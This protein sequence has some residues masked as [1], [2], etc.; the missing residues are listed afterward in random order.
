MENGVA[1]AVAESL[2]NCVS[3][4]NK[5]TPK[6][7]TPATKEADKQNSPDKNEKRNGIGE[8]GK[9]AIK[10]DS[11]EKAA[12]RK[13]ESDS[14]TKLKKKDGGQTAKMG[15]DESGKV[16]MSQVAKMGSDESGKMKKISA[17]KA[18]LAVKASEE[19]LA[20]KRD[21]DESARA[22][23]RRDEEEAAKLNKLRELVNKKKEMQARREDSEPAGLVKASKER[24]SLMLP[25]KIAK[26]VLSRKKMSKER[27]RTMEERQRKPRIRPSD[28]GSSREKRQ[29]QKK[30]GRPPTDDMKTGIALA[31]E[32]ESKRA[33]RKSFFKGRFSREQPTDQS[34]KVKR[35][36]AATIAT[37]AEETQEEFSRK[38]I[39]ARRAS[40]SASRRERL[41]K[42]FFS[43]EVL[44]KGE[45]RELPN[46][47]VP[48][49]NRKKPQKK[50]QESALQKEGEGSSDSGIDYW[51]YPDGKPKKRFEITDIPSE[52]E[53]NY[54]DGKLPPAL[55]QP[56]P[57]MA[58][59][60]NQKPQMGG[61]L[62]TNLP[63][64]P[65]LYG[66]LDRPQRPQ[67][68]PSQIKPVS[69]PKLVSKQGAARKGTASVQLSSA[70][71]VFDSTTTRN[72]CPKR[73]K[74]LEF[75]ILIVDELVE[76]KIRP[77][78]LL[79]LTRKN[80]R[81]AIWSIQ[82]QVGASV[83]ALPDKFGINYASG[84]MD[85]LELLSQ[86]NQILITKA[87]EVIQL[88]NQFL[89]KLPLLMTDVVER[90]KRQ[91]SVVM[92]GIPEAENGLSP[93]MRL[94]H[95][96]KFVSG[97]L[98]S[99]DTETRPVEVYRMGR[100]VEGKPRIVKCVFSSR[101][102]ML[103]IL[104]KARCLRIFPKYKEVFV[105]RSMT[106]DERQKE[107]DLRERAREL[108]DN[109]F[110]GKKVY[111]VYKGAVIK[112]SEIPR[113]KKAH[114]STQPPPKN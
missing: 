27:D 88:L 93:S 98:D 47:E 95:T 4:V 25:P 21:S 42:Q 18:E 62:G 53:E 16:K 33:R 81:F 57:K 38:S 78:I 71:I 36:K 85:G 34:K 82:L 52:G 94:D 75:E 41:K 3:A 90:D 15:S 54:G 50:S 60:A 87:P 72:R 100:F 58:V 97:I 35:K 73:H 91:R 39:R 89:S 110:E 43:K 22:K 19:K 8:Q 7:T 11:D 92:Y 111:V 99:L 10:T 113:G 32:S 64:K 101:R 23:K 65:E 29:K 37:Q 59:P 2:K 61:N 107:R 109:E 104:S 84:E 86:I 1:I 80:I 6:K 83:F 112:A 66:V 14:S 96:E 28:Q 5:A 51:I 26:P 77:C 13:Q 30:L 56:P 12:L 67:Q 49:M 102:F 46:M 106:I 17:E 48:D 69:Q 24:Q 105:R 79:Q 45:S 114:T 9:N 55:A 20:Q 44:K 76:K 40:S 108:N 74:A 63:Q 103:D 70:S 68:A 31:E